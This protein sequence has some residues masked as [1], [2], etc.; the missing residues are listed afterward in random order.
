MYVRR[1]QERGIARFDGLN[2][3]HTFS[4]GHY[5]DS[6]HM[7][8]GPLRV[9]NE[10]KV[11]P[12]KG[13]PTHGHS[14][15]EIISYIIEGSL[16]HKDT[17]GGVSIITAGEIQ[18]ITAGRGI[19]HSEYNASTTEPVHFLQMWILPSHKGT[20]PGYEQKEIPNYTE[21]FQLLVSELGTEGS[22]SI[23]Q[24]IK[25]FVGKFHPGN[26]SHFEMKEG[27]IAWLQIVKGTI[28]VNDETLHAGDGA[29]IEVA[30]DLKF[31]ATSDT[32]LLLF[33]MCTA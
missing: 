5:F 18:R 3:C 25:L 27:R 30:I 31:K 19:R 22:L 2:S 23:G 15:M 16:E 29:S 24:D 32:E 1:S 21:N 26:I 13:F 17:T 20:E 10:D 4:F 9:I 11:K 6:K 33:D 14:D 8:F 7:G 12:G 28:E